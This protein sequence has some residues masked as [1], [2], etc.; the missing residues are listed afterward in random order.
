[1]PIVIFVLFST[2]IMFSPI[3]LVTLSLK[4]FTLGF[5]TTFLLTNFEFK[6]ILLTIFTIIVPNVLII[7]LYILLCVKSIS[8]EYRELDLREDFLQMI[9][10]LH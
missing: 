3:S 9:T 4:G 7:F 8:R 6:G 5:T 10:Q 2:S 1:M